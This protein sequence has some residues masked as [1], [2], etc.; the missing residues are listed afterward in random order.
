[1]ASIAQRMNA[2]LNKVD[3][4]ELNNLWQSVLTDVT[5]LLDRLRSQCTT[6]AGLRI[7]GGSASAVVQAHT[8]IYAVAN[9]VLVTKAADTDMAALSGSVTNAKFNV[10][11][12]FIDSAGTLT[13]VMGTEGATLAAVAWPTFPANKA[14]IGYTIVNPTGTGPFVGG[15]TALDDAT[16]V[17]NAVFVN[18]QGAFDPKSSLSLTA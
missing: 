1:M 6:S 3:G 14:C 18:V 13:S 15:T 11:V 9:G 12:H 8:A 2:L 5:N 10:F 16:V 7:K 17:P 4:L